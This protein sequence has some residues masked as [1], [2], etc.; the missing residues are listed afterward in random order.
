MNY[1]GNSDKI[2]LITALM[3]T[4]LLI[5]GSIWWMSYS[6]N[7]ASKICQSKGMELHEVVGYKSVNMFCKDDKG[8][9]FAVGG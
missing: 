6:S 2:F 9:L 3:L 5:C 8:Q 7:K 4:L 1:L